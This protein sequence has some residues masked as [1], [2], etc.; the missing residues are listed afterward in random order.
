MIIF[1]WLLDKR[2]NWFHAG[3]LIGLTV[4]IR[5]DGLTL[6]GP[7][8]LSLVLRDYKIKKLVWHSIG[9]FFGLLVVVLPY[10]LFNYVV[11]GDIWPNTFYAKQAEYAFL[12]EL[13]LI[14]RF[15]TVSYQLFIGIGIVLIPGLVFEIIN[16]IKN[17]NWERAGAM[18]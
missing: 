9:L 10:F 12:R 3:L 7:A 18:W 15:G 16:L 1:C 5:P 8:L 14:S 13:S 17:A 11:A 6:I 4:W 2:G